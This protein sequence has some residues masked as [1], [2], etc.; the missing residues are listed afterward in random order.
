MSNTCDFLC[1]YS[2]YSFPKL[3]LPRLVP[4]YVVDDRERNARNAW[5]NLASPKV[6]V[7]KDNPKVALVAPMAWNACL[8]LVGKDGPASPKV[9]PQGGPPAPIKENIENQKRDGEN[10]ENGR[11]S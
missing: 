2:F 9:A 4:V 1:L 8:A 3:G 10:Q 5:Q 11:N 7:G 6:L